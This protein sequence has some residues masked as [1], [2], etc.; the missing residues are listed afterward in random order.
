MS[1]QT[2]RTSS[3]KKTTP[4]QRRRKK[5]IQITLGIV[6]IAVIL[7]V[8]ALFQNTN[9]KAGFILIIGV[10]L[11][12]TLQRSRFCF[13]A[14]L[15]DPMLTGGTLLTKAVIIGLAVSSLLFMAINMS[16]FGLDLSAFD[17][18]KVA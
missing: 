1:E 12:Y 3:R 5:T 13:T 8:S 11:G 16:K 17:I 4:E 2:I 10:L 14:S 7:L 18:K 15:R 6:L 9:P